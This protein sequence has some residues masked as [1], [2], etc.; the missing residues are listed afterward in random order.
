VGDEVLDDPIHV[1]RIVVEP[2]EHLP[3]FE[4]RR[5]EGSERVRID[6]VAQRAAGQ[7]VIV[8]RTRSRSSG[9]VSSAST[10]AFRIGQPPSITGRRT[11]ALNARIIRSSRSTAFVAP[12]WDRARAAATW[13]IAWSYASS[14][15][16]SFEPKW[17]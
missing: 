15:S 6:V 5:E 1:G 13:P 12:S 8:S 14:A 16:C 4:R 7:R 10:A 9:W 3:A 2:G 17:L 11:P